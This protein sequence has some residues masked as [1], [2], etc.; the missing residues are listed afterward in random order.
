MHI[1]VMGAGAIGCYY[2][3]VLARARHAVTLIGRA[4]HVEA[5]NQSGLLLETKDAKAYM[6]VKA[7]TDAAA[8]AGAELVLVCVKSADTEEAG[9][10]MAP[11]LAPGAVI[12]SLQNGVD[13]AERLQAATG[14]EVVP[15]VVYVGTEM[16]GPGH[17]RH[18]GRGELLMGPAPRSAEIVQAFDS[19]GI[20]LTVS[21]EVR[22]ALWGK[23]IINC[24]YNALSAVAQIPYGPM[25]QVPG[26]KDVVANVV[27]ECIA[28]ARA[29]GVEMS[30]GMT[31]KVVAL[32]TTMPDQRSSTA[33]DLARGKPTEI[34]FLN[35]YVVRKGAEHGIPTPTNL[36]LQV[37]VKLAERGRGIAASR[38]AAA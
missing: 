28:V 16:A 10:A 15:T 35:G 37:M 5:I 26:A 2:G 31:P 22:K 14:R 17:V 6:P 12:L 18:H 9:R 19:A 27:G 20:K 3:A 13:N 38:A 29:C 4:S 32:S 8:V 33:Q 36:A 21:D 11:H 34:D 24:A 1:A 25:M 30:E 7:S 23:L